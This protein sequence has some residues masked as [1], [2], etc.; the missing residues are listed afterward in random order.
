MEQYEINTELSRTDLYQY[1]KE[2]I[3]LENI[4]VIFDDGTNFYNSKKILDFILNND[5]IDNRI[6]SEIDRYY[7]FIPSESTHFFIRNNINNIHFNIYI[8]N[9]FIKY[10]GIDYLIQ[11]ILKGNQIDSYILF[12]YL[13][14]SNNDNTHLNIILD[15]LHNSHTTRTTRTTHTPNQLVNNRGQRIPNLPYYIVSSLV[16]ATELFC[17]NKIP[18]IREL[19]LNHILFNKFTSKTQ[20]NLYN[21]LN[22]SENVIT[23]EN[24]MGIRF[25]AIDFAVLMVSYGYP[26]DELMSE[27]FSRIPEKDRVDI[28]NAIFNKLSDKYIPMRVFFDSIKKHNSDI[29]TQQLINKIYKYFNK[30]SDFYGASFY[31]GTALSKEF[32]EFGLL[33]TTVQKENMDMNGFR[34]LR[35]MKYST[36]SI[37]A[38]LFVKNFKVYSRKLK[39]NKLLNKLDS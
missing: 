34:Y 6:I 10:N 22:R 24:K 7:T 37:N 12:A 19:I 11:N 30:Y 2:R 32:I 33:N 9:I 1:E 25:D 14:I 17:C 36:G 35:T 23:Y 15:A 20:Y 39:L 4:S 28:L 18:V 21:R 26:T 38:L 13:M 16:K 5:I 8:Y 27:L 31:N 29:I 3:L